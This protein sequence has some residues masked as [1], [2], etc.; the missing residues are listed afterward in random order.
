VSLSYS[1]RRDAGNACISAANLARACLNQG[2]IQTGGEIVKRGMVCVSL[3]DNPVQRVVRE[4]DLLAVSACLDAKAEQHDAAKEKIDSIAGYLESPFCPSEIEGHLTQLCQFYTDN[5]QYDRA[6][7]E[8]TRQAESFLRAGM[9][10]P[11]VRSVLCVAHCSVNAYVETNEDRHLTDF[12]SASRQ[13][14]ELL[15]K[16]TVL[17]KSLRELWEPVYQNTL[18]LF[19]QFQSTSD[20][21]DAAVAMTALMAWGHV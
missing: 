2:D 7:A 18:S 6:R 3:I 15:R 1:G 17:R 5:S 12:L 9:I 13:L 16:H 11:H 14:G 21:D 8:A 10:E 19:H 4:T 20:T